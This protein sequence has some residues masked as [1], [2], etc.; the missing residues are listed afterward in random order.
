MVKPFKNESLN[1]QTFHTLVQLDM[2]MT[3]NILALRYK[4]M[5]H[6]NMVLKKYIEKNCFLCQLK[7]FCWRWNT[8]CNKLPS[9]K[10]RYPQN[11][12]GSQRMDLI[13]KK[14]N[15]KELMSKIY[16]R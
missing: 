15:F 10:T 5:M 11:T 12:N 7:C 9:M 13:K 16:K 6:K 4:N 2:N 8:T 3:L 1:L 14:G